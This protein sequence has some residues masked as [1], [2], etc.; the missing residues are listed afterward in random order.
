MQISGA[1]YNVGIV[2]FYFRVKTGYIR[3]L[4]LVVT[5][6]GY[7]PVEIFLASEIERVD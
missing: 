1:A 5:V 6:K 3:R 2:L 7:Y 4:M